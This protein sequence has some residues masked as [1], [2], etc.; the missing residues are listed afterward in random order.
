M[1]N[2]EQIIPSAS[3]YA[4]TNYPDKGHLINDMLC[5]F[6]LCYL[7]LAPFSATTRGHMNR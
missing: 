3:A 4:P 5:M 7:P 2:C 6:D 1:L